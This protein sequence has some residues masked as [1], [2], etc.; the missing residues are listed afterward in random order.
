M[1]MFKCWLSMADVL[2]FILCL[3]F[4]LVFL[5]DTTDFRDFSEEKEELKLLEPVITWFDL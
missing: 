1:L 2:L 4:S 3:W 5:E